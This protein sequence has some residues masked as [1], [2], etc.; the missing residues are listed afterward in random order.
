MIGNE[1]ENEINIYTLTVTVLSLQ[2]RKVQ[3]V[4]DSATVM[5]QRFV[6][7]VYVPSNRL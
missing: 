2:I 6:V 1:T 5:S 4:Q 7:V 3:P